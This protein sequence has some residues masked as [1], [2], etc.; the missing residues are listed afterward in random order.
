LDFNYYSILFWTPAK[1]RGQ[2]IISHLMYTVLI[3]IFFN[4]F[5]FQPLLNLQ[6]VNI[7]QRS[8]AVIMMRSLL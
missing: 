5:I 7:I 2:A 3:S 1:G 4:H 6:P 8:A